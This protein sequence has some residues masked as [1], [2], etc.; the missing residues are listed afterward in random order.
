MRV[1]NTFSLLVI[2]IILNRHYKMCQSCHLPNIFCYYTKNS[3]GHIS[4][5]F[6]LDFLQIANIRMMAAYGRERVNNFATSPF[7]RSGIRYWY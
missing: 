7:P 1:V 6:L 2:H 5:T 4:L 3:S